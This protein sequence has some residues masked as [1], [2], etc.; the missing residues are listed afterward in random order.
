M[1]TRTVIITGASQGIGQAT[2]VR[3]ANQFSSLVLVA[4]NEVALKETEEMIHKCAKSVETLVIAAD[5]K[6]PSI[7][8]RIV[9]TTIDKFGCID[10]VVNIAGAVPQLDP[11]VM[12]D[13]QWDDGLALK[14]HAARRLTIKA[15]DHLKEAKGSVIFM[16]GNSALT[17]KFGFAAVAT[18]NAAIVAMSKAFADQGLQD[19]IQVNSVLP[20]PVLTNRRRNYL[21][22]WAEI[23][24]TTEEEA[25]ESFPKKVGIS[26]FGKPE[27]IAGL[28]AFVLSPEGQ[29][30]TGSALL[31]DGG[32]IKSI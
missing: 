11:F 26:R 22:R 31:M 27:E 12:T 18:I 4:R 28:I 6:E 10:A 1:A 7:S 9:K 8:E 25:M 15:W 32:E 3:L 19:G 16:S 23:N 14:L 24:G 30:M 20:G 2:A 5:L 13:S 29:W 21:K 17:P